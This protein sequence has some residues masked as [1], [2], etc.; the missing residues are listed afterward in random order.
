MSS[1]Y[2]R[3]LFA[4]V[5]LLG[6][7]IAIA[8]GSMK[9]GYYIDEYYTYTRANGTGIGIGITEGEW[10]DTS[11]YIE[12][13]VSRG[14]E[15]FNYTQ[16]YLNCG[17]HPPVYHVALHFVSSLFPGVFSKWLGISVNIFFYMILLIFGMLIVKEIT[18][19]L[20]LTIITGFALCIAPTVVSQVLF[21]R[22]YLALAAFAL[23]HMYLH[24]LDMR[25]DKTSIVRFLLPLIAVDFL[26]F[27]TMY[28][29]V[30]FMF[31]TTVTYGVYL[32]FFSKRYKDAIA[33]GMSEL[34]SLALCYFHYPTCVYYTVKRNGG[35]VGDAKKSLVATTGVDKRIV[36]FYKLVNKSVFGGL[37]PVYLLALVIGTVLIAI[38]V[39]KYKGFKNLPYNIR[40]IILLVITSVGY[41][42]AMTKITTMTGQ[43]TNRYCFIIYPIFIIMMIIGGHMIFGR[44]KVVFKYPYILTAILMCACIISAY[45]MGQLM[46]LYTDGNKP[47]EFAAANPD[48]SMVVINR[49]DGRYDALISEI[50]LY[51]EVYFIEDDVIDTYQDEKIKDANQLLVYIDNKSD[52]DECFGY[53]NKI[54]P[55]LDEREYMWES[56]E[57]FDCYLLH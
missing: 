44:Y 50:M 17:F 22:M 24:I 13:L 56:S 32:F 11:G 18:S 51:D 42:A 31:I 49:N 10:N 19:D 39:K 28:Y 40:C 25:R 46:Y 2:Y 7:I 41:F 30:I 48:I 33:L 34:I 16:T 52:I 9:N 15:N 8:L 55:A 45:A 14:S 35:K 12:E 3:P 47:V 38:A 6:F 26:G 4:S 5:L 23:I 57:S 1:K 37:L 29:F 21:I 27:L 43:G 54:N 20:K 53:L 36:F